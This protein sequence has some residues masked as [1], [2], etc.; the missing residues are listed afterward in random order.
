MNWGELEVNQAEPSTRRPSASAA[1]LL[2]G[3]LRLTALVVAFLLFGWWFDAR[4]IQT[5]AP[6][7]WA[8]T[9]LLWA[10]EVRS[11]SAQP[12]LV[13]P[14]MLR[15]HWPLALLLVV[16]A[17][18]WLPF[19]DNWRWAYTGDS[20]SFF[21][22]GF[23]M[24]A[25]GLRQN[26]L[27]VRGI[28]DFYTI[29]WETSYNFWM[30]LLGPT[31]FVHRFGLFFMAC[32]AL[33]ATYALYATLLSRWWALAIVVAT[34]ANYVWLWMS[35]VSYLRMD[36]IVIFNLMLLWATL[37]WRHPERMGAYLLCGLTAG[38]AIFYTPAAWGAVMLA[39]ALAVAVAVRSKNW[40][41]VVVL[42]VSAVLAAVPALMEIPWYLEMLREQSVG[43]RTTL[44]PDANY[45]WRIFS[46]LLLSPYDS[47]ITKLGAQG[48]FL[49]APL[50]LTYL[51]G[52]GLAALALV[53]SLCRR[54]RIPAAAGPLLVVLLANALLFALTN[55]GYGNFSH[56]RTYVII[57]LQIFFAML[58]AI[59]M[60]NWGDSRRWWRGTIVAAVVGSVAFY[61]IRNLE[62]IRFP[63]V[64]TYG[65]NVFD[66]L[67]E[68]RQRW[69]EMR[70]VLFT[71][72]TEVERALHSEEMFQR[73][74]RLEDTIRVERSFSAEAID[75][76]CANNARLCYERNFDQRHME[77]LLRDRS[78]RFEPF[79]LLNS[80]ELVCF[81][82]VRN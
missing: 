61:G 57:P 31:F 60:A 27:S 36:G 22:V 50:G 69:P 38:L 42:A 16:F 71:S 18:A 20:I 48:A 43:A 65:S 63:A 52:L 1:W 46:E 40:L 15:Q 19:Y 62:L 17:A 10:C 77:P 5:L 44:R 76:A 8:L 7:L 70:A 54:L 14:V 45:V 25:S 24:H 80:A 39:V 55:K 29:L 66:G 30:L 82:C 2:I 11:R 81:T 79:P 13:Q 4:E 28:D 68:I 33:T 23:H 49:Q 12:I 56:K 32:L 9:L 59:V 51:F 67:I 3:Y 58:P 72:R 35:Y 6:A 47:P 75:A 53:P 26:L 78:E 21:G 73:A 64:G 37:I 74:Y 41:A 34:A